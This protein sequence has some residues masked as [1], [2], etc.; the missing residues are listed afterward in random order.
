M[1]LRRQALTAFLIIIASV[2]G[3]SKQIYCQTG[4]AGDAGAFLKFGLGVR[5]ATY[6]EAFTAV[7]SDPAA[8]YYNP[9]GIVFSKKAQ[10]EFSLNRP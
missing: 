9:A 1:N 8:I 4:D 3:E 5:G 6:G 2:L 10:A 7:A